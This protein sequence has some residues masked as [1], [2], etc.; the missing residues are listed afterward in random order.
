[1]AKDANGVDPHVSLTENAARMI[2]ARLAAM[3]AYERFLAQPDRVYELHQ[4]RIAAKRL[5]YTLEIFQDLY[6]S[7]KEVASVYKNALEEIRGLQDHLGEIHDADVLVPQLT[8]H[9]AGLLSAGYGTD[10]KGEPVVGVHRVDFDACRGLL[11]LCTQTRAARDARY[12]QLLDHWRRLRESQL[13]ERL[14]ALLTDTLSLPTPRAAESAA[15]AA[16]LAGE[17]APT[18]SHAVQDG[19]AH[20]K[21][22]AAEPDAADSSEPRP[23]RRRADAGARSARRTAANTRRHPR[24]G[25]DPGEGTAES[26]V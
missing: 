4:M 8:E 16:P 5:R 6:K 1:M 7:A 13:F 10:K 15:D 20:G 12:G 23:A 11:T 17:E 19:T 26:G 14:I 25:S 18:A 2:E 9:L 22:L 24:H 21:A 3:L